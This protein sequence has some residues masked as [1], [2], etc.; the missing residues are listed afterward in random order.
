[1]QAFRINPRPRLDQS[2][3][4]QLGL[5]PVG[6]RQDLPALYKSAEEIHRRLPT[7]WWRWCWLFFISATRRIRWFLEQRGTESLT[8]WGIAVAVWWNIDFL[9]SIERPLFYSLTRS[10]P[11][12][13]LLVSIFSRGRDFEMIDNDWN[14]TVR[15]H[16]YFEVFA[17]SIT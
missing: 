8:D 3:E 10:C 9:R 2:G 13:F 12:G 17:S 15:V 4:G 5:L 7:W 16:R 11:L 6:T 1:M 14:V